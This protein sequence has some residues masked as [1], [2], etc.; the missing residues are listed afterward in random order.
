MRHRGTIN[1]LDCENLVIL[2]PRIQCTYWARSG[3]NRMA[4][5]EMRSLKSMAQNAFKRRVKG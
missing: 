5:L 2:N 4:L 3:N 1:S